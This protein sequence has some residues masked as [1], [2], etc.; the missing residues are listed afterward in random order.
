[1]GVKLRGVFLCFFLIWPTSTLDLDVPELEGRWRYRNPR[2]Q[3]DESIKPC[4]RIQPT[5]KDIIKRFNSI[6]PYFDRDHANTAFLQKYR[7]TVLGLTDTDDL[8]DVEAAYHAAVLTPLIFLRQ[9]RD[10]WCLLQR[11]NRALRLYQASHPTEKRSALKLLQN[12]RAV[13]NKARIFVS[14]L[15]GLSTPT[16]TTSPP[17]VDDEEIHEIKY[18]KELV[19]NLG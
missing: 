13:T 3:L 17:D 4:M 15:P 10:T 19:K 14:E 11:F 7:A 12:L 2:W 9:Y 16:R 5:S 6:L 8:L 18:V 1:M